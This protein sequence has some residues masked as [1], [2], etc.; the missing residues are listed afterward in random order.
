[1]GI[2][3]VGLHAAARGV[4][5]HLARRETGRQNFFALELGGVGARMA[6][7]FGAVLLVLLYVPVHTTAFVGT[8]IALLVLSTVVEA[9]VIVRRM[10]QG[11]LEP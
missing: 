8:V 11:A 9:R 7:V 1:M 6:L 2:G 4:T 10:D 3:V 5:H